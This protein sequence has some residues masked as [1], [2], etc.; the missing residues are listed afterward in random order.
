MCSSFQ[1]GRSRGGG[2]CS[3]TSANEGEGACSSTSANGG[4]GLSG[5]RS[6]LDPLLGSCSEVSEF[7]VCFY[8]HAKYVFVK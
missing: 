6:V 2:A 7:L 3:S 8:L 4:E 5:L 1:G